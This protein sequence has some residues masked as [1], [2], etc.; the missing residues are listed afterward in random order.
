MFNI[1]SYTRRKLSK[2]RIKLLPNSLE[3]IHLASLRRWKKDREE[4]QSRQY[5]F[6]P[7]STLIDVGGYQGQW[8]SDMY[9]R[10]RS[11]II[12]FEPIYKF[13]ENIKRRFI[14]NPDI[15]VY[16]LG[17][18]DK[19]T[20]TDIS[21]IADSSSVYI[22]NHLSEKIDLVKASSFLKDH[23]IREIDLMKINIEGGEYDLLPN[24][25]ESGLIKNIK[26]LHIQF[27][28]FIKDAEHR[29]KEIKSKLILTHH[30]ILQYPFVWE[31]WE[32]NI[33]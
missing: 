6:G 19:T 10:Y 32:R 30:P 26:T 5:D 23:N 9:A 22:K 21:L 7:N 28:H 24:L 8:C 12:V 27:H 17:L 18:S 11:K 16:Q 33:K 25:I 1:L 13:A 3:S 2:L 15:T 14:L 29:T 4:I 31:Y 20:K